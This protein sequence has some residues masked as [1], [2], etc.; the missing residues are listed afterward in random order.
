[1]EDVNPEVE[2]V[3]DEQVNAPAP[4]V[5]SLQNIFS[6]I[7]KSFDG[8]RSELFEFLSNCEN[9]LSLC[10]ENQKRFLLAFIFSKLT[11]SARSQI[12]DKTFNNWQTLKDTLITLYS[13]CKHYSQL[14]EELNTVKQA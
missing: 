1:M 3:V 12:Q 5:F 8:N 7:P 9:A 13:D 10:E 11:G 2:I 4:A 6:L 14:M